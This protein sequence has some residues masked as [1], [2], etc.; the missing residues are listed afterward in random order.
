[1]S[2]ELDRQVAEAMGYTR[3]HIWKQVPP[4]KSYDTIIACIEAKGLEMC[5]STSEDGWL[6]SAWRMGEPMNHVE[7]TE[8]G[9]EAL[10]RAFLKAMEVKK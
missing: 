6:A 1:M 2:N 3:N 10:C 9:A 4:S 5:I 7:P 8:H